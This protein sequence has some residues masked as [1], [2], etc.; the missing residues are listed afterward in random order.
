MSNKTYTFGDLGKKS[1]DWQ[2]DIF[3][4]KYSTKLDDMKTIYDDLLSKYA[5]DL[6][7]YNYPNQVVVQTNPTYQAPTTNP[8]TWRVN[9]NDYATYHVSPLVTKSDS[10][11]E[12]TMDDGSVEHITREELVKYIGERKLVQE[13]EVVRKMYDRF[14]VAAKLAR[15][16]DDG[17]TGV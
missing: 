1:T 14:Q 7:T 5:K 15:S 3:E 6:S 8:Y 10:K 9:F 16:D 17:D 11:V 12:V 13:N 4:D 2:L